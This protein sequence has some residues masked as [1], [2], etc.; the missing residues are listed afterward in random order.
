MKPILTQIAISAF[1]T[2]FL[3]LQYST[4]AF[5]Q[6]VVQD[7]IIEEKLMYHPIHL[8]SADQT[9]LPWYSSDLGKSYDFVIGRVWG[10]WDTMRSDRTASLTI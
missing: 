10:F 7:T 4:S 5:A 1:V 6:S 2:G 8:N 3:V 9:I